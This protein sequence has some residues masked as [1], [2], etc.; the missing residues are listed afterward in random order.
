M[1]LQDHRFADELLQGLDTLDR[2]PEKVRTHAE[3]LDRASSEGPALPVHPVGRREKAGRLH[4]PARHAVRREFCCAVA[5]TS[6]GPCAGAT[7]TPSWRPLSKNAAISGTAEADIEK[8][9]KSGY[10]TGLTA[11]HPFDPDWKLPVM[12]ANFVLMG[13]GTGAIFGCPAHDQRD[14]DFARKYKL[15][16]TPVVVPSDADPKTF[17]VGTEAYTGPGKLANSRFLDGMTV[18]QAK[19]EVASRVWRRTASANA[20]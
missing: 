2:W 16:V 14:L 8:A 7:R 11:T 12:V 3:E 1:V 4:H 10:D 5:R 20:R 15:S 17:D 6:A 18:E 9:E 19:A 13:Y